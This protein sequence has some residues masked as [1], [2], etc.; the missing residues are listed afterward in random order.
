MIDHVL[1][2]EN[3]LPRNGV[4][5]EVALLTTPYFTVTWPNGVTEVAD[6]RPALYVRGSWGWHFAGWVSA[7]ALAGN[8]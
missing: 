5:G 6:G 4:T 7:Y 8:R 1:Q 2:N 3:E